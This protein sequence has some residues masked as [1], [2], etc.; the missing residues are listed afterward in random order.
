MPD[1]NDV[2][3]GGFLSGKGFDDGGGISDNANTCITD[4]IAVT[5]GVQVV[6][7]SSH[8]GTQAGR[9][10]RRVMGYDGNKAFVVMITAYNYS[11]VTAFIG[12]NVFKVLR[13]NINFK[14]LFYPFCHFDLEWS[15]FFI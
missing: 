15:W 9:A 12:H 7:S 11:F 13:W 5:P 3:S 1:P 14:N 6:C 8:T 4:Y 2:Y 10:T